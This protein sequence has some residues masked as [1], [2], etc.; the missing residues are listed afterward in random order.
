MYILV[1]Y[2]ANLLWRGVKYKMASEDKA[3]VMFG[4]YSACVSL[5]IPKSEGLSLIVTI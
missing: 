1:V 3:V 2:T 5:M 4:S